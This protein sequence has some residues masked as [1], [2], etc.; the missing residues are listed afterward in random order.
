ME[1]IPGINLPA[2]DDAGA[3]YWFIFHHNHLLMHEGEVPQLPLM[4]YQTINPRITMKRFLGVL[5]GK[6]CYVALW[7]ETD[8]PDNCCIYQ[9]RQL[10]GQIDEALFKLALRALHLIYWE[11]THRYCGCCGTENQNS[12]EEVAK[13]CPACGQITYPRIAPAV[14]VAIVRGEQILLARATRF[15]T[16]MYS[17]L[18]GFVEPG[19]TLEECV[20]REIREEVGIEVSNIRYFGSQPW[21]FPD[22]L[23]LAFTAEYA[24]GEL[25]LDNKELADAGWF[26]KEQLP[27]IPGKFSIARELIDWFVSGPGTVV[28]K[29]D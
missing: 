10:F 5:D 11:K 29:T 18:A 22:S 7:G 3:V 16:N 13:V 9:L 6:A 19:E 20:R 21:P 4:S 25:V 28:K 27:E 24:K 2:N 12:A 26:T 23:M 14:I 8:L 15:P 17:V 1:F